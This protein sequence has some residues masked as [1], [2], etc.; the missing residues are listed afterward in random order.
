M[1]NK[2]KGSPVDFPL[3]IF[4]HSFVHLATAGASDS[5]P[6][7]DYCACYQAFVCMYVIFIERVKGRSHIRCVARCCAALT[8]TLLVFY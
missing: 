6:A 4:I 7:V 2:G 3:N 5:S 1:G 8:K